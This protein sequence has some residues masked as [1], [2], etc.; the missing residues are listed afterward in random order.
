MNIQRLSPKRPV[1]RT[2]VAPR[3]RGERPR[4]SPQ[5]RRDLEQAIRDGG[6]NAEL[7]ARFGITR[8]HVGRVR[9]E[10]LELA[11]HRLAIAGF[12]DELRG[13]AWEG[14][15]DWQTALDLTA[16][17]SVLARPKATA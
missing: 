6:T 14:R 15:I 4:P 10:I 2:T 12:W 7:A 11:A 3:A 16:I 5:Q 9:K 8:Q 13:L 17:V 1:A